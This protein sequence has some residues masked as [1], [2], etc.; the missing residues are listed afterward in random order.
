MNF[1]SESLSDREITLSDGTKSY[2]PASSYE[3]SQDYKIKQR[4]IEQA[5]IVED[6]LNSH[7]AEFKLSDDQLL[8]ELTRKQLRYYTIFL[9]HASCVQIYVKLLRKTNISRY[10][11]LN[12]LYQYGKENI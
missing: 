4:L 2:E 8:D 6:I 3:D 7:G 9:I 10:L 11:F 1:A 5:N 12:W